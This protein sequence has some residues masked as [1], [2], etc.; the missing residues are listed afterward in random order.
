MRAPSAP[1]ALQACDGALDLRNRD[2]VVVAQARVRGVQQ[3]ARA[4]R[5]RRL[6]R[7]HRGVHALVLGDHVAHARGRAGRAGRRGVVG[8]AQRLEA[9]QLERRAALLAT[10]VVARAARG[11]GRRARVERGEHVAAEVERRPARA[12]S[13][14]MSSRTAWPSSPS[15]RRRAGRAG[16]S[17]GRP[18]RSRPASTAERASIGPGRLRARDAVEREGERHAEGRG[19]GEPA[20]LRQVGVDREPAPGQLHAGAA[21]LRER[22]LR[23]SARR[24]RGPAPRPRRRRAARRHRHAA[25]DRE[26]QAKSVVVVGVLADQVD[27]SRRESPDGMRGHGRH[28]TCHGRRPWTHWGVAGRCDRTYLRLA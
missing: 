1:A 11:C 25:L 15:E 10:L 21:Q 20:P 28:P 26:R 27:A 7:R 19:R 14:R 18:T 13:V 6:E 12:S 2:L 4:P 22:A 5:G 16:R 24:P 23:G 17:P 9:E 3:R 8:V